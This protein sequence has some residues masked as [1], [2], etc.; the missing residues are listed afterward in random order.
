LALL[1]VL[2]LLFFACALQPP[3]RSVPIEVADIPIAPP[4][5]SGVAD[6]IRRNI[7][8][9]SP[10]S[11]AAA[12]ALIQNRDLGATDF[13]RLMNAAAADLLR[14]V[15]P[16]F[17]AHYLPP[18]PPRTAAYTR[19][20][21]YVERGV[22]MPPQMES[23]DFLECVLPFLAFYHSGQVP[24]QPAA[25]GT[26]GSRDGKPPVD[27]LPALER[28]SLLNA[29]SALPY[30]F[31]G[32]IYEREGDAAGAE[33]AYR[34]ALERAVD[35][36][37]AE[38]GLVRIMDAGGERDAALARLSD[39]LVR[40]PDNIAIKKELARSHA[41]RGNWSAADALIAE[42]LQ[43]GPRDGEF[44]LLRA[45]S[46]MEQGR[47]GDA[48]APLDTYASIDALNRD[49]LFL[50]ARFQFEYNNNRESAL[51]YLR[52]IVRSRPDDAGA[53]AY[54][55][56]LLLESPNDAQ[57]AEGRAILNRLLARENPPPETLSLAVRDA[58]RREAWRDASRYLEQLL[59]RRRDSADL[60]DAFR[61]ERGLGNNG[62][63]LA[64]ARELFNRQNNSDEA[65]SAYITALIDTGRRGEA[66][67]IISRRLAAAASG[68]P[69]SRYYYLRSR[70]GTSDDEILNDLRSS[71]FEDP[72]NLDALIA[73]FDLY[74]RRGDIRRAAHYLKQAL[75][76]NP[77][78]P[79]LRRYE[80]EYRARLGP[81]Y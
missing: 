3:P 41:A 40:Y 64:Y 14:A 51:N 18:D 31:R 80:T 28:A 16:D 71:L 76:I 58:I 59:K 79:S 65:A 69:K 55:A 37:P 24:G 19:I 42:V 67:Q 20:L 57:T 60:F 33:T 47:H 17:P 78:H 49:Y 81:N 75:A 9:G 38:L 43:R 29:D 21:R 63:A 6:E 7:E 23:R 53:Q 5:L 70:L 12:C 22:Y 45:R 68:S 2:P 77:A 73:L 11:L 56:F 13:G 62:S 10:R 50:R 72:R 26:A 15:Y 36:Y 30:L 32:L 34:A 39:L 35:C 54:M 4:A 74:H 66:A 25:A 52:S 46:A 1:C 48:A 44:L 8:T 61:V 27:A